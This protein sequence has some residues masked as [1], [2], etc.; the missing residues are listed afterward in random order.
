MFDMIPYAKD[1]F[2]RFGDGENDV[3]K[4]D[5]VSTWKI[6]PPYYYGRRADGEQVSA[7]HWQC[8]RATEKE[9]ISFETDQ[10]ARIAAASEKYNIDECKSI[11]KKNDAQAV[12]IMRVERDGTVTLSTYGEN[13]LKCNVIGEWAKKSI[14]GQIARIPFETLFGWGNNGVPKALEKREYMSLSPGGKEYYDRVLP[15]SLRDQ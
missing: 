4:I 12:V 14:W 2:L 8:R 9:I 13:T 5:R 6:A 3:M 1:D 7:T 15:K 11:A 10:R